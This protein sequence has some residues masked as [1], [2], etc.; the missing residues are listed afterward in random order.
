MWPWRLTPARAAACGWNRGRTR[1]S[2]AWRLRARPWL[3]YAL[4]ATVVILFELRNQLPAGQA[5]STTFFVHLFDG[6]FLVHYFIEAFLWK[7][8]NPYYRAA[9]APLYFAPAGGAAKADAPAPVPPYGS[10][11]PQPAAAPAPAAEGDGAGQGRLS[12]L[13]LGLCL[14]C[15]LSGAAARRPHCRAPC[16]P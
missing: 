14:A 2:R 8:G 3:F 9:L 12:P 5:A 11:S 13:A 7:F 16:P 10:E 15:L 4:L 6:I 1:S